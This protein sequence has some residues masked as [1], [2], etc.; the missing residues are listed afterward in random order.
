MPWENSPIFHGRGLKTPLPEL[1][2][3]VK[4]WR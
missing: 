1:W 4:H 2:P 3:K